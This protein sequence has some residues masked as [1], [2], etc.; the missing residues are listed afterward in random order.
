MC[1]TL[2]AVGLLRRRAGGVTKQASEHAR[3]THIS[4][5]INYY[6]FLVVRRAYN[7]HHGCN[8][9]IA[10][11]TCHTI[12]TVGC[13]LEPAEAEGLDGLDWIGLN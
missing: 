6:A 5:P 4:L 1:A 2:P 13:E 3:H 9:Y 11:L 7:M 12:N 8:H 10:P